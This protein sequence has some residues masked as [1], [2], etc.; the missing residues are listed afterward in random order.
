[1]LS[2]KS[3]TEEKYL[4]LKVLRLLQTVSLDPTLTLALTRTLKIVLC[5]KNFEC[6]LVC[7]NKEMRHVKKL[8]REVR[9][10]QGKIP[11]GS[12]NH[13]HIFKEIE[14]EGIL[15]FSWPVTSAE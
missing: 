7:F 1:M 4:R 3:F 13:F 2:L 8:I 14:F 12:N 11:S 10:F 6:Q 15:T 5:L 9:Y